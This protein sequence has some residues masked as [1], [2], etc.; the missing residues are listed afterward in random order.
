MDIKGFPIANIKA[1]MSNLTLKVIIL[2]KTKA[3]I[4]SKGLRGFSE[5][6]IADST[7]SCIRKFK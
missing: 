3:L 7:G 4:N 5:L 1:G 6:K 2:A